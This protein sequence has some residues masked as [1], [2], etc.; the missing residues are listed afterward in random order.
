[1]ERDWIS[2]SSSAETRDREMISDAVKRDEL[3]LC[4]L[5]LSACDGLCFQQLGLSACGGSVGRALSEARCAGKMR[6]V[7]SGRE[8]DEYFPAAADKSALK[9]QPGGQNNRNTTVSITTAMWT[10]STAGRIDPDW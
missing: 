2:N 10:D 7:Q 4:E 8:A 5:R 6:G 9:K 3:S 1:M